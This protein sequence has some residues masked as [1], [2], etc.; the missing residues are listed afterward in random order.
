MSVVETRQ[1]G[2]GWDLNDA[3]RRDL[4]DDETSATLTNDAARVDFVICVES[5]GNRL[6]RAVVSAAEVRILSFVLSICLFVAHPA[7][8]LSSA[9]WR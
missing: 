7:S 6:R 3:L 9:E 5:N 1:S 4:L 8:L 2:A